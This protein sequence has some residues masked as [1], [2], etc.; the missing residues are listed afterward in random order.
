VSLLNAVDELLSGSMVIGMSRAI[1]TVMIFLAIGIAV[2]F[3]NW[4]L[5][6]TGAL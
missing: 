4:A 5:A 3:A 1:Q 6:V 2:L